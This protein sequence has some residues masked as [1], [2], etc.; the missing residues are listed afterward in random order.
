MN[1]FQL[2]DDFDTEKE[3]RNALAEIRWPEGVKCPRCDNAKHHY[4][5]E[6][7]VWDCN[8]CGYQF[9]VMSGTIFH[10]TKLPLRK[11][12]MAVLLMVEARKGISANQLKRTIG[13][14]YKTAWYLSHRIRAAMKDA[15]APLLNG[16]IEADETWIGGEKKGIGKGNW[17]KHKTMVLGAV[18][19]GGQI[20]L[21]VDKRPSKKAI[22]EFLRSS[23]DADMTDALMT[24]EHSAYID[25]M[26]DPSRHEHVVHSKEEWV[27]GGVHT[28][29][30]EGVWSLLKRSVVGSYHQLSA[31][32]L[33]AYLDEFAFRF[34]NRHNEYLFR[35]TLA[36]LV[37]A[38]TLP[39]QELIAAP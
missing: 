37:T 12:F 9:S 25:F 33:P 11:W 29:S 1:L 38:T 3:C 22:H 35:D 4:D 31:K 21:R 32:H 39:Y 14:S 2:M 18:E 30:V 28:N 36:K 34:N 23:V 16:V 7:Y 20:R 15:S 8:S 6:R 17:R 26:P 27:R 5:S 19:R 10:D 13:V 24:D